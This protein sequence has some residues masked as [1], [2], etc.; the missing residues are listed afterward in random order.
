MNFFI[1]SQINLGPLTLSTSLLYIII[2]IVAGS[3]LLFILTINNPDSRKT[4]SDLITN[5]LLVVI[6]TWKLLPVFLAPGDIISSPVSIL[7][8]SGGTPG[9]L[10]GVGFGIVYIGIKL[11]LFRKHPVEANGR[12]PLRDVLKYVVVFFVFAA[13]VSISLFFVSWI[14]RNGDS[15]DSHRSERPFSRKIGDLAPDFNLRDINGKN[16]SLDDYRGKW[17]ILNFWATWCPPCRGELPTLIRFYE[18]ADKDKIVLLGIN[19]SNTEKPANSKDVRSYVS[20]FAE[21]KGINYPIL[22]DT[23]G[24]VSAIY[25]AGTLPTTVIVSPEGN[26]TK[27]KTGAVDTFWLRSVTN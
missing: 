20:T 27:I 9:I 18:Q 21:E 25:G 7:Y 26:I 24:M 10:I 16:I 3:I 2:G 17:V 12:S 11:F 6:L 4:S 1:Y 5:F 13:F 23:K 14:V 15:A 19:A 22:L 8:S